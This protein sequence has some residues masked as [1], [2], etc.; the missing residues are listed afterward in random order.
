MTTSKPSG[1]PH[2]DGPVFRV[3]H[4][5]PHP[6]PLPQAEEPVRFPWEEPLPGGQASQS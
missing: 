4:V 2:P 3:N 6:D 1:A 5:L